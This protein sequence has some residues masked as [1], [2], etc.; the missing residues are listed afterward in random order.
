MSMSEGFVV[1]IGFPI[2]VSL[3]VF[4]QTVATCFFNAGRDEAVCAAIRFA[5][6]YKE[7]SNAQPA[8][9]DNGWFVLTAAL[10]TQLLA[11]YKLQLAR[12]EWRIE[13]LDT[14]RPVDI[15]PP[16]PGLD[17]Q[18]IREQALRGASVLELLLWATRPAEAAPP[19]LG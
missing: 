12:L 9:Y 11:E 7:L 2:L 19:G 6:R 4:W 3:W 13:H 15:D 5:Q 18:D 14:H 10:R 16:E 8:N 17:W 1:I